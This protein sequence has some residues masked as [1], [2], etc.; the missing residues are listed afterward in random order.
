MNNDIE[1]ALQPSAGDRRAS[2]GEISGPKV[3][4]HL[5]FLP[6][7]EPGV[8]HCNG[9]G[10]RLTNQNNGFDREFPGYCLGCLPWEGF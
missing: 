2:F 9:C 10:N 8:T 6:G 1:K 3:L 5:V 4:V 7:Q